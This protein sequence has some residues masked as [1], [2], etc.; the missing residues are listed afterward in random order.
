MIV[1]TYD[2]GNLSQVKS[3]FLFDTYFYLDDKDDF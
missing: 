2:V 3:Y 1:Y